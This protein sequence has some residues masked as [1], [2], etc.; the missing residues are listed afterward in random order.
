MSAALAFRQRLHRSTRRIGSATHVSVRQ[1][2]RTHDP[3]AG[4]VSKVNTDT[5]V[6]AAV[7]DY[8]DRDVDGELVRTGD[9]KVHISGKSISDAGLTLTE[10]DSLVIGGVDYEIVNLELIAPAGTVEHYIAQVRK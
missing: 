6:V 2:A 1:A 5:A 3:V 4:T 7:S 9:R 8:L 10:N